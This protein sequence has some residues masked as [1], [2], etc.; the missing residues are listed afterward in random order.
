MVSEGSTSR[1]IV[2]PVSVLIKICIESASDATSKSAK[3]SIDL[4]QNIMK[5]LKMGMEG[6]GDKFLI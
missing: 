3:N 5:T 1:V 4:R 6:G 2:V